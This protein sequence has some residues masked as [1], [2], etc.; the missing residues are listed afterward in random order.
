[1][2][3][4]DGPGPVEGARAAH[5]CLDRTLA[6]VDDTRLRAPSLLPGWSVGHVLTHLARNAESHTRMLRAAQAGRAVQQ[7]PG[8]TAQ[9]AADI[10]AGASRPA[11]VVCADVRDTAAALEATWSA[12]TSSAWA[13]HGLAGE[14][15]WPCSVLVLHRWREVQ[16]HHADLGVGYLPADWPAEYLRAD[17]PRALAALP[18]RLP[19]DAARGALLAW[20][21]DRGLSPVLPTL[22]S[23]QD[24]REYYFR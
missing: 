9:R 14:I 20:L 23:W 13:G 4:P 17:L 6:D 11:V 7:Y 21:L 24:R 1:M 18:D 5:E 12:M 3:T 8:G 15:E 10:E 2:S 16:V 22:A 19:D